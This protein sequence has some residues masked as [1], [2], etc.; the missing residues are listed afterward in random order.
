MKNIQERYT[1]WQVDPSKAKEAM[2]KE[3]NP[4]GI[5]RV[6]GPGDRAATQGRTSSILIRVDTTGSGTVRW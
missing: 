3:T 2:G 4:A 1:A 6:G 5:G